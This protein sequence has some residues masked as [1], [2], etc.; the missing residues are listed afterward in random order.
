MQ[1]PETDYFRLK[2]ENERLRRELL[3][4]KAD[5]ARAKAIIEEARMY[6]VKVNRELEGWITSRSWL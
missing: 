6:A 5:L 4:A 1:I 2:S 3:V